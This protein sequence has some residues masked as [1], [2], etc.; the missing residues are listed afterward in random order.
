VGLR[1]LIEQA[2]SDEC[3]A[4]HEVSMDQEGCG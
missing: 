4:G 2:V 3:D 1:V